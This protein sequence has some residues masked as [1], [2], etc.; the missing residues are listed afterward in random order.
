[1]SSEYLYGTYGHIDR[2]I[3]NEASQATNAAVYIGVAPINLIRGFADKNLVDEPIKLSN[4]TAKNV[5]GYSSNWDKFTLSEVISAH[6][7]NAKGNIGPIYVIN[8]MDP[9]V[10]KKETTEHTITFVNG[11][12]KIASDTIII[13]S[14]AIES[15]VEGQDYE[16]SYNFTTG[17]LTIKSIGESAL[18]GQVSCTYEEV[19]I[20]KVTNAVFQGSKKNGVYKGACVLDKLYPFYGIVPRYVAAPGFTDDPENYTYL[21]NMC[22]QINN[23]WFGF[24]Y[25]D[26][27]VKYEGAAVDTIE[28]AD[29]FRSDHNYFEQNSKI[30]WPEAEIIGKG[31]Y[32]IS[33]LA[34]VEKM[35]ADMEQSGQHPCRTDGNKTVPVS[36]LYFGE[37]NNAKGFDEEEGNELAKRGISTIIAWGGVFRLWGDHTAAYTFDQEDVLDKRLLFDVNVIMLNYSLNHFQETYGSMIDDNMSKATIQSITHDFN[38]W[39]AS[40]VTDGALIGTPQVMFLEENNSTS[41]M[42]KGHFVWNMLQTNAPLLKAAECYASYT[43][44]GIRDIFGEEE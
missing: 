28:K 11:E 33:T 32:H 35:R 19:D 24:V 40:L 27:P 6:F 29:K 18:D 10:H 23:H 9:A 37:E 21:C 14:F 16:L 1:M 5:V 7:D 42:T 3:A 44:A 30:Y 31:I 36:R 8:I 15:K 41:S 39:L 2:T 20:D 25:A 13:D 17:K 43:D 4:I 26:L 38:E 12:A 34:V 22:Y